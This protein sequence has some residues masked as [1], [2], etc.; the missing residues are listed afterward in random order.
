MDVKASRPEFQPW[1]SDLG[2]KARILAATWRVW[3]WLMSQ[4]FGLVWHHYV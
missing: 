1:P 2:L 3:P 4:A